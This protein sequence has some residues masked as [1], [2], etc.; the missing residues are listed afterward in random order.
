MY[1]TIFTFNLDRELFLIALVLLLC[2]QS[3]S[4]RIVLRATAFS[5][6]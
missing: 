2:M 4:L 5:N 1:E 3:T 6:T